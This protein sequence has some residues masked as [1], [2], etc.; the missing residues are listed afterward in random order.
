MTDDVKDVN[1]ALIARFAI[2]SELKEKIEHI[3]L[4]R[5]EYLFKQGDELL[6]I[7]YLVTGMLSTNI[8]YADGT[9]RRIVYLQPNDI[10]GE[11][12]ILSGQKSAVYSVRAFTDCELIRIGKNSFLKAIRQDKAAL[13]HLVSLMAT[14]M[15]STAKEIAVH[16]QSDSLDALG[17]FIVHYAEDYY[18]ENPGSG[19]VTIRHTRPSI[20]D[21]CLMSESSV[22]RSVRRLK[23]DGLID[24]VKGKIAVSRKQYEMLVNS[25]IIFQVADTL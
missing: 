24:L 1:S 13:S 14:K 6:N 25:R 7:Y 22:N 10:V 16:A 3:S 5:G 23:S 21:A 17:L 18:R 20:A 11:L 8:S 2:P 19:I 4:K 9:E 15:L 12:E